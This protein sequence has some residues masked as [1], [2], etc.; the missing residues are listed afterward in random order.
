MSV[1]VFSASAENRRA[2]GWRKTLPTIWR[3]RTKLLVTPSH[4]KRTPRDSPRLLQGLVEDDVLI[5]R[6]ELAPESDRLVAW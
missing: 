4:N 6:F 2:L 3:M 1:A 5:S